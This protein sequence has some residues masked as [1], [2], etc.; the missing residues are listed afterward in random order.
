MH[1]GACHVKLV[2]GCATLHYRAAL[3]HCITALQHTQ[4]QE[5]LHTHTSH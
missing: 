4:A 2:L 3:P 5:N 1:A